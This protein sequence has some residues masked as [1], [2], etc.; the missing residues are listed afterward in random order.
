VVTTGE[1][2]GATLDVTPTVLYTLVGICVTAATTAGDAGCHVLEPP[3]LGVD[4]EVTFTMTRTATMTTTRPTEPQVM[5][6]EL[7]R[8]PA[9][10]GAFFVVTLRL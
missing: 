5:S 7:D 6:F 8:R 2:I 1:V 9:L 10:V 4:D 3:P